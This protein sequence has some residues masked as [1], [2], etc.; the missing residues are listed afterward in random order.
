MQR[1]PGGPNEG[2]GPRTKCGVELSP[3]ILAKDT[4]DWTFRVDYKA[5]NGRPVAP[6]IKI[7]NVKLR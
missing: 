4:G 1:A 6:R 2:N 5:D 3:I 7:V